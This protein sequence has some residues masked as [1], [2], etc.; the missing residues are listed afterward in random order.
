MVIMSMDDPTLLLQLALDRY[1][2]E[3]HL[4]PDGPLY[5]VIDVLD[6][7]VVSESEFSGYAQISRRRVAQSMVTEG[8]EV[9]DWWRDAD[10]WSDV[11]HVDML[12][13]AWLG[14][15]VACIVRI[16]HRSG[17]LC[18]VEV[19]ER[20]AAV[21]VASP[22]S[23]GLTAWDVRALEAEL[24]ERFT[25]DEE[26]LL[27]EAVERFDLHVGDG[28]SRT[29]REW[30]VRR[31]G[32][33]QTSEGCRWWRYVELYLRPGEPHTLGQLLGLVADVID[34]A[35]VHAEAVDAAARSLLRQLGLSIL[36]G[37]PSRDDLDSLVYAHSAR[38]V[39]D[40]PCQAFM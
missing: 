4:D 39:S 2:I 5:R 28:A 21:M 10:R 16:G 32:I 36:D 25:F 29:F 26:R 13:A 9:D 30:N 35:I 8:I 38:C 1:V 33:E 15:G 40:H 11:R 18:E 31:D 3:E 19:A 20:G 22:R 17:Y 7:T 14:S 27:V 37:R 23:R 6:D 12:A 34:D 24:G